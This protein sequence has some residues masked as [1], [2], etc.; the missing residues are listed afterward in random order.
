MRALGAEAMINERLILDGLN[1]K[2]A[3]A[4]HAHC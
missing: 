4:I 2:P 3:Y 1:I